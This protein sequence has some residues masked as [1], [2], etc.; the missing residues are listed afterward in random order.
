MSPDPCL[1]RGS[2][3]AFASSSRSELL[4]TSNRHCCIISSSKAILWGA[5][6]RTSDPMRFLNSKQESPISSIPDSS[7]WTRDW[8][9]AIGTSF[10]LRHSLCAAESYFRRLYRWYVNNGVNY[11]HRVPTWTCSC[12]VAIRFRPLLEGSR[13]AVSD[14]T[15]WAWNIEMWAEF[16]DDSSK[17]STASV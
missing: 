5:F 7:E 10:L 14:I 11:M 4:L 6:S 13:V 17:T 1:V 2:S 12:P 3:G 8:I 15:G 16:L 9:L